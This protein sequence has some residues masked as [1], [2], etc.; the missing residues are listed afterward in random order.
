[1]GPENP[2]QTRV[3]GPDKI[4]PDLNSTTSPHFVAIKNSKVQ[5]FFYG[6]GGLGI[7]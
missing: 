1:M 6:E 4:V 7:S 2:T 5:L 3:M